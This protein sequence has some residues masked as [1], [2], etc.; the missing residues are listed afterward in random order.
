MDT[1]M[2]AERGW[3][4]AGSSKGKSTDTSGCKEEKEWARVIRN[5]T[6]QAILCLT[7]SLEI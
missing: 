4:M 1:P 7:G 6:P 2:L 3:C 5:Y